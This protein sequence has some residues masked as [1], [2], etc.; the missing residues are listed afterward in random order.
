MPSRMWGKG[1]TLKKSCM[2]GTADSVDVQDRCRA[3][4]RS[5]KLSLGQH[6][7][8]DRGRPGQKSIAVTA[9]H[10]AKHCAYAE[11]FPVI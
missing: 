11:A 5:S 1:N 6:F 10:T 7:V 3:G 8:T 4:P 2:K 9:S